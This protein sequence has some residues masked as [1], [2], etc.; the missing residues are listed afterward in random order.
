M[1]WLGGERSLREG[2][3]AQIFHRSTN[4]IAKVSIFGAV[5]FLAV[6]AW[7]YSTLLRSSYVTGQNVVQEAAGAVQ[8]RAPRRA[9][10]ASTAATATPRSSESP[11]PASRRPRPA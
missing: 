3:M 9:A 6:L 5:F 8:P 4:T 2:A 11:S 1:L 7:V 10:S